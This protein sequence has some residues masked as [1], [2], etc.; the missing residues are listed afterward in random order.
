MLSKSTPMHPWIWIYYISLYSTSIQGAVSLT[1][2]FLHIKKTE[3]LK[4]NSPTVIKLFPPFLKLTALQSM[5]VIHNIFYFPSDILALVVFQMYFNSI[6][7]EVQSSLKAA[8]NK[9]KNIAD[10][11]RHKPPALQIGDRDLLSTKLIRLK[12]PSKMSSCIHCPL[13]NYLQKKSCLLQTLHSLEP[14]DFPS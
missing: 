10:H 11:H 4:L 1:P 9:F 14:Q 3:P 8:T 6:W 2:W 13:Y 12:M 7:S 5:E